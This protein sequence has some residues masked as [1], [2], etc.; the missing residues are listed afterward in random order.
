MPLEVLSRLCRVNVGREVVKYERWK[1]V[2]PPPGSVNK[3]PSLRGLGVLFFLD[4]R[5]RSYRCRRPFDL[6]ARSAASLIFARASALMP[7]GSSRPSW[8]AWK[9]GVADLGSNT[10]T[11]PAWWYITPHQKH[12]TNS[13]S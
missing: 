8:P 6:L 13:V 4:S 7:C 1:S 3:T 2:P 10:G 9:R 11:A 12:F 5:A